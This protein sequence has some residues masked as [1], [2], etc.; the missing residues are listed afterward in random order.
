MKRELTRPLTVKQPQRSRV[1]A[2]RKMASLR[3]GIH[4]RLFRIGMNGQLVS[5]IITKQHR[6]TPNT[7]GGQIKGQEDSVGGAH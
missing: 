2:R 1:T 5:A 6:Q 3:I 7:A 4:R